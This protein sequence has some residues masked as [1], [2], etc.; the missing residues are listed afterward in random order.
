MVL[1]PEEQADIEE[2]FERL[3][4]RSTRLERL[5][6]SVKTDNRIPLLATGFDL[7]DAIFSPAVRVYRTAD[8]GI[9]DSTTTALTFTHVDYDTDSMFSAT[10]TKVN[11]KTAG[12]YSLYGNV[13]W[14]SNTTGRRFIAIRKNGSTNL[15]FAEYGPQTSGHLLVMPVVAQQSLAAGDY[16]ELT[17]FQASGGELD[18]DAS[19]GSSPIFALHWVASTL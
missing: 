5:I 7:E 11:I 2:R 16:V 4:E 13:R 10:D 8:N 1:T 3:E 14:E 12:I 19:A 6:R 18:V 9:S 17:V 15:G